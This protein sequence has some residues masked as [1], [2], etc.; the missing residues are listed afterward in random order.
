M[1][2]F[3]SLI[4][5][6]GLALLL[7]GCSTPAYSGGERWGEIWRNWNYE[8]AQAMDDLDHAMLFRPASGMTIW[9]VRDSW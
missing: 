3:V 6:G 9:N 2:K 5:L 1:K 8:G 7:V 4:L